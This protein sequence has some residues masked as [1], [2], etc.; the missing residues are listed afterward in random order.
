[1]SE[2]SG[3]ALNVHALPTDV[4]ALIFAYFDERSRRFALAVVCKRWQQVVAN[5]ITHLSITNPSDIR[6]T[7][8]ALRSVSMRQ[9]VFHDYP[10]SFTQIESLTLTVG[11]IPLDQVYERRACK[12]LEEAHNN[13]IYLPRL[14]AF[15]ADWVDACSHVAA[16]VEA[17]SSQLTRLSYMCLD[18][19]K[20]PQVRFTSALRSLSWAG[21]LGNDAHTDLINAA[22]SLTELR[23][24]GYLSEFFRSLRHTPQFGDFRSLR[25][26]ALCGI[27]LDRDLESLFRLCPAVECLTLRQTNGAQRVSL[28]PYTSQLVELY[29]DFNWEGVAMY[30]AT[31][32]LAQCSRLTRLEF[33]SGFL[34]GVGTESLWAPAV[35]QLAAQ[36]RDV[37]VPPLKC[38]FK[39][40]GLAFCVAI[41][42]E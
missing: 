25:S 9:T 22:S 31:G 32:V 30:T 29:L 36:L 2:K 7:Y 10:E 17:H 23:L 16:F 8:A 14:T 26:L 35:R 37:E 39:T 1:M 21:L 5:T 18:S 19:R 4:L 38:V 24:N 6:S 41:E 12:R 34:R 3:A 28:A 13:P 40:R 27:M 20:I 42:C 33:N 11:V 15:T